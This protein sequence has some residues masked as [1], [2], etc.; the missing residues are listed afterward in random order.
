MDTQLVSLENTSRCD[1]LT[2]T[3]PV[4][5]DVKE[6]MESSIGRNFYDRYI[7]KKSESD[8]MMYFCWIYKLVDNEATN[9]GFKLTPNEKISLVHH[10][11]MNPNTRGKLAEAFHYKPNRVKNPSAIKDKILQNLL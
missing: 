3:N 10:S 11:I 6:F 8:I 4:M 2:T 5:N 7:S 9:A 1:D